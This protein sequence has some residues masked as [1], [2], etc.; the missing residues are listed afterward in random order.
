MTGNPGQMKAI[1]YTKYGGPEVLQLKEVEKP[2]PGDDEVL[3]R[4]HAVSIND[5]DFGLL[6]GDFIN[7]MMNGLR[8]PKRQ[9]LGSDI[10][11]RIEA[12][13]KNVTRFKAGD[14]VYGDLSGRWGGFA[15][16]CCA[17]E[18]ALALKSASMS[19]AEAAAIPQAAMLAV[20]GLIDKGKIQPGQKLLINGAGGGVGTFGVQVAKL[21]GVEVTGVDSA[22]K[23]GMM[24]SIGFDHVIDYARE[25]FTK[26]GRRYDLILD[27]KTNRSMSDYACALNPNGTYVT[28]GGSMGRLFQA[29]L[30]SPWISMT[31]KKHFRIVTLK[32]NKDLAYM[33]GL[34]E[35]GKVRPVI[36]GPYALNEFPAAFALFDKAGHKGK[37]VITLPV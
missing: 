23:L 35:S 24:R 2:S 7:R 31:G 34:Y 13:G 10:A 16:Y 20:Q 5:W 1:V 21:Y 18:K 25:D 19:F 8:K 17:P 27:A 26:N 22:A 30:L 15:E 29:L 4:N 36:D 33:N 28:V 6:Q 11:G 32:P 9:I 14:E 3:I 12:V 37:V